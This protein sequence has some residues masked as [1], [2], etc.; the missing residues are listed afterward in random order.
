MKK[1]MSAMLGLSLIVG[2]ASLFAQDAP[3][4][5][6]AKRKAKRGRAKRARP[7]TPRT[8]TRPRSKTR[9]PF[10]GNSTAPGPP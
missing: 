4:K 5:E 7:R 10:S 2:S 6:D 1:I 3:K 9:S 8:R